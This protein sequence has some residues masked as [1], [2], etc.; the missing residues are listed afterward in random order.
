MDLVAVV[1]G[2]I[3]FARDYTN[4]L[5]EDVPTSEWFRRPAEGVTHVAWQVGHLAVGEYRIAMMR[6]RGRRPGDEELF[7]EEFRA[8][9][10][11]NSIPDPDPARNPGAEEIR[12]VFDRVHRQALD[13][14]Q[15]L[16]ESELD[17]PALNPLPFC[18]TKG[19]ALRW[20][21]GHEM[22]HAGQIGLLRRLLGHAPL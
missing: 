14:L 4:K 7:S 6:L 17:E 1:R 3:V 16:S 12:A 2:Q 18:K 13:E 11:A 22:M 10:G 9:F 20:C 21:A 8:R 5:L 19:E 15:H